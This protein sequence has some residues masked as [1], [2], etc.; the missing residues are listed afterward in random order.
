[1]TIRDTEHGPTRVFVRAWWSKEK[2]IVIFRSYLPPRDNAA[3]DAKR[4]N[5][6]G[7]RK[8][9]ELSWVA[10]AGVAGQGQINPDQVT[11]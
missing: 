7:V 1:M 5:W 9:L 8:K 3:R 10:R 11:P 2:K 6:E 4:A